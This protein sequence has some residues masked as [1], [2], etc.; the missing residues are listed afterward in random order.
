M[1]QN[2]AWLLVLSGGWRRRYLA[3]KD[4]TVIYKTRCPLRHWDSHPTHLRS[5]CVFFS[6]KLMVCSCLFV[7]CCCLVLF[8]FSIGFSQWSKP[9]FLMSGP[10]TPVNLLS[11]LSENLQLG[12]GWSPPVHTT[13]WPDRPERQT[14]KKKKTTQINIDHNVRYMWASVQ[15]PPKF[16][17]PKPFLPF[18]ADFRAVCRHHI[19]QIPKIYEISILI[20][21]IGILDSVKSLPWGMGWTVSPEQG[22]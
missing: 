8:V 16:F 4:K 22:V 19:K 2:E 5:T 13:D 20:S 21:E 10:F 11:T 1:A 3:N 17:L 7:C 14:F 12:R 18:S 6:L 15:R 9:L